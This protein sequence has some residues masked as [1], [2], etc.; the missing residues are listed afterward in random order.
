[1][2]HDQNR[3]QINGNGVRNGGRAL[4]GTFGHLIF[5]CFVNIYPPA[6]QSFHRTTGES[7]A[8]ALR[9]LEENATGES[10]R[11]AQGGRNLQDLKR[12][13]LAFFSITIIVIAS[14][15]ISLRVSL[16]RF[17]NKN[18]GASSTIPSSGTSTTSRLVEILTLFPLNF[19]TARL[20]CFSNSSTLNTITASLHT[21][22]AS[23]LPNTNFN[24]Q[25]TTDLS[26][27]NEFF[28][29]STTSRISSSSIKSAE[30]FKSSSPGSRISVAP[31]TL[32][33]SY[34]ATEATMTSTVSSVVHHPITTTKSAKTS[35]SHS[36]CIWGCLDYHCT[37]DNGCADPW[38]CH[39]GICCLTCTY[40]PMP[41]TA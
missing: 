11:E 26:S 36:T 19:C 38:C 29:S 5:C 3:G 20:T 2:E 14:V 40:C 12:W 17:E 16:S 9:D 22:A 23:L 30:P 6:R 28:P 41:T 21:I 15:I 32:V 13:I 10:S 24:P 18:S 25:T 4:I 7:P 34:T 35:T 1:M 31:I 39:H 37:D 27:S 33:S 8:F